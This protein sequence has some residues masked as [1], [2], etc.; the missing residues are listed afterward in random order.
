[1]KRQVFLKCHP[2]W[3]DY[4]ILPLE[5]LRSLHAPSQEA[6]LL[7]VALISICGKAIYVNIPMDGLLVSASFALQFCNPLPL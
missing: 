4:L 7:S 2:S 5:I 1:M 6:C 3:E